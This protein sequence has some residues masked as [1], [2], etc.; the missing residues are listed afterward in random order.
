MNIDKK[1]N[2]IL[3]IHGF[4]GSKDTWESTTLE[5]RIPKYLEENAEIRENF[6]FDYF[7]YF[8]KL[9]DKSEKQYWVFS[10][11][12]N[13]IKKKPYVKLEQNLSVNVIKDKL[14]TDIEVLHKGYKNI[15]LIAHSMGGLVAKASILKFL[16]EGN[17]RISGFV[18]LAVPHKGTNLALLGNFV[19]SN[20]NTKDL[21][22]LG[23]FVNQLNDE[24]IDKKDVLPNTLYCYGLNDIIVPPVSS[25]SYDAREKKPIATFHDHESILI[26]D[27]N[28]DAIIVATQDFILESLNPKKQ[29]A[30][31]KIPTDTPLKVE[32][33]NNANTSKN[34]VPKQLTKYL[35]SLTLDKIIGRR[36]DIE[37]LRESL[38]HK[39][40][41]VLVN[42]LGGI[43]KTTLAQVYVS[44]F[45]DKYHHIAWLTQTTDD[46]SLELDN[47]ASLLNNLDISVES[48]KGKDL[49]YEVMR[50]MNTLPNSPNLLILDNATQSLEQIRNYLPT[51]PNWHI[52]VTSREELEG[53]EPKQ[54]DFLGG[55]DAIDLFKHY[56]PNSKFTDTEIKELVQSIERHTLTIEILAK[57]AK[58]QHFNFV[59]L[60][61]ALAADSLSGAKLN[62]SDNKPIERVTTYLSSI[63]SMSRLNEEEIFLLKQFCCFP[64]DFIAY[65][66]LTEL[67]D[68]ISENFATILNTLA[69]KGWI[70]RNNESYKMH[71][72]ITQIV[73]KQHPIAF[74]DIEILLDNLI[75]L[76]DT[77]KLVT[78]TDLLRW[79]EYVPSFILV[80]NHLEQFSIDHEN[81]LA[82]LYNNYA[83]VLQ[84][85]G[86]YEK[87]K[88]YQYKALISAEKILGLDHPTTMIRYSNYATVLRSI[89][90]YAKAKDYQYKALLSAEKNLGIDHPTTTVSYSIYA[91]ILQ[92]LGN[93]EEARYYL[94]KA[95]LSDEKNFGIDHP[96]TAIRYSNYASVL[97]S[98]GNFEEAK[99]YNYKAVLSDEKNFGIDHPTTAIRYSNYATV[100]LDLRNYAE[101]EKYLKRAIFSIEKN[102]GIDHPT[103]AIL[104]SNYA[105]V[106]QN[107]GKYEEAK[108]YIYKAV[109]SDEK[110]LGIDHPNTA[111]RYSNY[112]LLL[113]DLGYYKEAKAYLS[114]AYQILLKS[115]GEHH[116]N[117]ITVKENL[118]ILNSN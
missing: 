91:I 106:L 72:I 42:G 50:K 45:F 115:L 61:N 24:W 65:N 80:L 82:T 20:P 109:L 114:K 7:N 17:N 31:L 63:F 67:L 97:K 64:K 35:P 19:L 12:K 77:N 8:T 112:A 30:P 43:G 59:Q 57:T 107:L 98:L 104:Y 75:I 37:A 96:T 46:F 118:D 102:L 33:V 76:L 83:L 26:P 22:A 51:Q 111:V 14:C 66:N 89:G 4:T 13:K 40:Q 29:T 39:R 3:F 11:L 55:E 36:N 60:K 58:I 70:I 73:L 23:V 53:F 5:K 38:T 113:Q 90:N 95:V 84:D 103:T 49:F 6:D 87:A 81:S 56:Y 34:L 100:L 54:L 47:D 93:Y 117:T 27:G 52:L 62:R 68:P 69:Q 2:L 10:Y 18:S 28:E 99:V 88:D 101:A 86:I 1:K 25:V 108:V 79:K 48:F 16:N 78:L 15:I 110:N 9:S 21:E 85:L 116:P 32:I 105:M 44:H 74:S 94:Y 41:V 92:D 71:V